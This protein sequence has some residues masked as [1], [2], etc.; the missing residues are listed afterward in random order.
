LH[1]PLPRHVLPILAAL[2][3]ATV[4]VA[5]A[6]AQTTPGTPEIKIDSPRSDAL[7]IPGAEMVIGGWA[8]DPAGPG[9]GIDEVRVYL[10]GEMDRGGRLIGMATYGKPRPDVAAVRGNPAWANSGFDYVWRPIGLRPGQHR[11]YVYA[12]SITRGWSH[13]SVNIGGPSSGGPGIQ[14]YGDRYGSGPGI[15]GYGDQYGGGYGS[16]MMMGYKGRQSSTFNRRV[17]PPPPRCGLPGSQLD[18][19]CP[20][21]PP[22]PPPPLPPILAPQIPGALGAPTVTVGTVTPTMVTLAWTPVPGAAN[23]RVLVSIGTTGLFAPANISNLTATGAIVTGLLPNTAYTFQVVAVDT[24]GNQGV[25][26]APV[27]VT[28]R[29]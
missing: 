10:D 29:P 20:P 5:P 26:S 15:Q 3:V 18:P 6:S 16:D 12:R 2:L 17:P 21:P 19:R 11:I 13:Q 7:I 24:V 9:T 1:H 22:P 8:V 14:G 25:A 28:T 27:A 4:A 23:Y